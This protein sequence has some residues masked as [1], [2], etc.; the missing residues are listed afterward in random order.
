M[1]TRG[2]QTT[3]VGGG[4]EQTGRGE[5]GGAGMNFLEDFCGC[6]AA[7]LTER[8]FFELLGRG[9]LLLGFI[10]CGDELLLLLWLLEAGDAEALHHH[11]GVAVSV[12]GVAATASGCP[13][14][15]IWKLGAGSAH[16]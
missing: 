7:N 13:P 4:R 14:S 10:W 2:P 3:S 12:V 9:R 5:G 1:S 16:S 15:L 8:F 11:Y 6:G